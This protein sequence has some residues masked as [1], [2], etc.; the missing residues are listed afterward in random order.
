LE[1]GCSAALSIWFVYRTR[2]KVAHPTI[3]EALGWFFGSSPDD[4]EQLISR[5]WP[6]GINLC[7]LAALPTSD[8]ALAL[9]PYIFEVFDTGPVGTSRDADSNR[10]NDRVRK[11]QRGVF[12]TP[13]DVASLITNTTLDSWFRQ[14]VQQGGMPRCI[15]PACGTGVFLVC[16]LN[17]LATRQRAES[18]S[19][20]LEIVTGQLFG[21]DLSVQAVQAA[22]F[23]MLA[24]C[25]D[26]DGVENVDVSM[27]F[28]KI[29]SNLWAGDSTRILSGGQHRA[30][31]IL[32]TTA[33]KQ[34]QDHTSGR[35]AYS[36][37]D[38][39]EQLS[40]LEVAH[41][42]GYRAQ[43]VGL[44]KFVVVL[45]NPPYSTLHSDEYGRHRR[46]V[47][48]I[49]FVEMMWSLSDAT[50][51]SGMVVPLS[52]AYHR[53]VRF[54]RLRSAMQ[55]VPGTWRIA[56]FDR[57][58][59][60]LFSDDVKTRNAILFLNKTCDHRLE[61]TA[62]LRWS[63]RN[64]ADFLDT[65]R[66]V[67]VPWSCIEDILP[68]LGSPIERDVYCQLRERAGSL[69]EAYRSDP[70]TRQLAGA[71]LIQFGST[72]Y[73]WLPVYRSSKFINPGTAR[74]RAGLWSVTCLT[75][76]VA[77]LVFAI[78]SSRLVYW[79]WRV[80]ADGFHL[81]RTFIDRVPISPG[82]FPTAVR[83]ELAHLGKS[84]WA[85]IIKHPIVSINSGQ[86]SIGYSPYRGGE[87]LDQIDA[88]LV[89][90][91]ELPQKF[92]THLNQYVSNV[93]AAG[94]ER[95]AGQSNALNYADK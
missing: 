78:V 82:Q 6:E 69:K 50:G 15:D 84:L 27:S 13:Y 10:R 41:D 4:H 68:K 32:V 17:Y 95:D 60:S 28:R 75:E 48:F 80:K 11:R 9:L 19:E 74:L 33:S 57:T 64:R 44:G 56:Y 18:C 51:A 66:Y 76:E 89:D 73:N 23:V 38:G 65:I 59:D 8:D 58:P 45:G 81:N 22:G 86:E 62:L 1:L 46:D 3:E 53:G 88:L 42:S 87:L 85:E 37:S 29:V 14:R 25:L 52:I 43:A 24:N 34:S 54:Q 93:I 63:S 77:D 70:G 16:A 20:R 35:I 21:V 72:A 12:Y 26:G 40:L 36:T 5:A 67:H 55:M 61:T 7:S 90:S 2:Y 79:L 31:D 94:R 83:E 92:A 39:S 30:A 71:N 49:P 47:S 91:L